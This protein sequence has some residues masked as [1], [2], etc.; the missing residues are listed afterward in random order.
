MSG[1]GSNS[2][3]DCGTPLQGP[4]C[5]ACGQHGQHRRLPF[6]HVAHD[7][8]HDLW[9]LDAKVGRTLKALALKPGLLTQE[10]LDGRRTRWVPP[11]RLYLIVTF[12]FFLAISFTK[13]KGLNITKG[14][15]PTTKTEAQADPS[16]VPK[17]SLDARLERGA[18][19]ANAEPEKAQSVLF[20][21]FP[22]ALFL[23]LPVFALLLQVAF[24]DKKRYFIEHLVFSLHTHTFAFLVFLGMWAAAWLPGKATLVLD[25]LLLGTLPVHLAVGLRR[26]YDLGWPRAL[27]SLAVL[28][29]AYGIILLAALLATVIL[30][31]AQL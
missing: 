13:P 16:P 23:L 12:L 5:H 29:A 2:C 19:R 30:T 14:G 22:R 25:L 15:T 31:L 6:S 1:T 3:L 8:L 20:H 18:K 10:Y 28:G 4:Y 21:N 26:R 9:H 24:F 17:G 27:A 7:V 11:F